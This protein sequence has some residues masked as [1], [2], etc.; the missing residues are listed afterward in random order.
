MSAESE[1]QI[2]N[3]V[4]FK[5]IQLAFEHVN[6]RH[7]IEGIPQNVIDKLH[8]RWM[9]SIVGEAMPQEAPETNGDGPM[10]PHVPDKRLSVGYGNQ[11]RVDDE[12]IAEQDEAKLLQNFQEDIQILGDIGLEAYATYWPIHFYAQGSQFDTRWGVYISEDGIARLSAV[13]R[14]R[15]YEQFGPLPIARVTTMGPEKQEPT[16]SFYDLAFQIL[17]RH[18]LQHFKIEAFAL[19]AE[20]VYD[21]ALYVPYLSNVYAETYPTIA[22]LEEA[23]A[24]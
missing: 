22:C 6:R 2:D 23:L 8:P 18:E 9:R 17:L 12:V 24:N 14:R 11:F 1:T 4:L 15:C 16:S 13:L 5:F 10:P 21:R 20:L 7:R 3:S 19:N